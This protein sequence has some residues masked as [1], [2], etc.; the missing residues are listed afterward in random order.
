MLHIDPQKVIWKEIDGKVTVLLLESG[1]FFELN[2]VGGTVWKLLAEGKTI[3]A[4][5]EH[6]AGTFAA[7]S[8]QLTKDVNVF[9]EHTIKKGLLQP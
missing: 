9:I 5:I 6:M 1:S 3:S 2:K 7:P 4:I 8:H